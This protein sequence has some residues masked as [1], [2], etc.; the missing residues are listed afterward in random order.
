MGVNPQNGE[1]Y[2][3]CEEKGEVFGSIPANNA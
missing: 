2:V 1:V 3:T